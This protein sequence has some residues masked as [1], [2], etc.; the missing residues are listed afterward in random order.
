[1]TPRARKPRGGHLADRVVA[2]V[3]ALLTAIE[4][5]WTRGAK[6]RARATRKAASPPAK[7][8][9]CRQPVP[10][11]LDWHNHLC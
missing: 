2:A 4:H 10:H 11:S 5:V 1:V 6:A 3:R 7:C 8:P 9:T